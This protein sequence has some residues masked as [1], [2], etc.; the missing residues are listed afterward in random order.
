MGHRHS[1]TALSGQTGETMLHEAKSR[2]VDAGASLRRS[3][4]DE[5]GKWGYLVAIQGDRFILVAKQFGHEENAS[6][7]HEAV[8]RAD[9]AG[10]WLL[11]Y[12]DADE[13]YTVFSPEHVL[14]LDN[15]SEGWSKTRRARWYEA[16]MEDGAD[17]I[18]FTKRHERPLTPD[19]TKQV[20][21]HNFGGGVVR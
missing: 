2:L 19:T 4:S 12:N 6:F 20:G 7:L 3:Y 16:P 11:F 21:M 15:R 13:S 14:D 8:H 18:D 1:L 5:T 10:H 9:R 17:I